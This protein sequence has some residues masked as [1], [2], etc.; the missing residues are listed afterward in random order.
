MLVFLGNLFPTP[1]TTEDSIQWLYNELAKDWTQ[2]GL[3][4]DLEM[5]IT[6]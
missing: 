4:H 1:A 3:P 5:N 6:K 2:T